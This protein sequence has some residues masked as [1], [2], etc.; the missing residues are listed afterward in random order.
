[1]WVMRRSASNSGTPR[2]RRWAGSS[3][4]VSDD[5]RPDPLLGEVLHGGPEGALDDVVPEHDEHRVAP[6]EPLGEAQRLG[7]APGPVLVGVAEPVDAVLVAVAEEAQE[8]SGVGAPG[9]DHHLVDPGQDQRLDGVADHGA[10]VDG[11]EVLVGDPG[12][13]VQPR[14]APSR[15]DD[16]LHDGAA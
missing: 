9:D 5:A 12:E 1:M 8:F 13:R 16:A 10:V 7:D 14:P 4:S 6:H 3:A 2:W 11:Q 15:Q